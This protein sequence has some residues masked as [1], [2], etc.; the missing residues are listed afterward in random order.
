MALGSHTDEDTC[1]KGDMSTSATPSPDWR[2][3]RAS[4][5]AHAGSHCLLLKD[6]NVCRDSF[7]ASNLSL[8]RPS[9]THFSCQ[10]IWLGRR[11]PAVQRW[12]SS[13]CWIFEIHSIWIYL[14]KEKKKQ[15]QTSLW[16]QATASQM[17]FTMQI[18]KRM[19]AAVVAA[20]PPLRPVWLY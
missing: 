5:P 19:P 4:N 3:Q 20:F 10:R 16:L 6:S 15:F 17:T 13:R 1:E 8:R 14:K 11:N 18:N 7:S 9:R 12:R 2:H